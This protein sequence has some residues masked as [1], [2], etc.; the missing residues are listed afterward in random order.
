[1]TPT[2]PEGNRKKILLVEDEAHLAFNLQFNMQAEGYDVIPAV[3]G[4]IALEKY[5][6]EGPFAAI[7]LDVNLPEL[8]GFEVLKKIREK[9]L[10]T[11]I[12]MLTARIFAFLGIP[13][14][15]L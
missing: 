3:D 12:I 14:P 5:E 10:H 7:V 15:S 11:G 1:M 2:K 6:S 9:D 8:D 4:L 13:L